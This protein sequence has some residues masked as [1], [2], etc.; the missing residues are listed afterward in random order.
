MKPKDRDQYLKSL[1][2]LLRSQS[3]V[4]LKK[5]ARDTLNQIIAI[6]PAYEEIPELRKQLQ[7]K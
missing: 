3:N 1:A 7:D 2:N 4:G 5:D 6:D